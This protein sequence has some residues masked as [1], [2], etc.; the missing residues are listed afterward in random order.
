MGAWDHGNKEREV[1]RRLRR[2]SCI[3]RHAPSIR[4]RAVRLSMTQGWP[5]ADNRRRTPRSHNIRLQIPTWYLSFVCRITHRRA[6]VRTRSD[7]FPVLNNHP[8]PTFGARS[9]RK[10]GSVIDPKGM[11]YILAPLYEYEIIGHRVTGWGPPARQS[12]RKKGNL[13]IG[14]SSQ[15]GFMTD[16]RTLLLAVR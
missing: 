5:R 6:D 11:S 15:Q 14:I 2:G 13:Y 1:E 12:S 10:M 3:V 8:H 7:R 9:N 16:I 4:Y